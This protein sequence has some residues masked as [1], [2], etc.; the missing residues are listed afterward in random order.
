MV[1]GAAPLGSLLA[2]WLVGIVG[3]RVVVTGWGVLVLLGGLVF[4][5]QL[6]RLR[7]ARPVYTRLGIVPEKGRT[8]RADEDSVEG[9]R[10]VAVISHALWAGK[11][12]SSPRIIDSR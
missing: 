8:F 9:L 1:R 10:P 6:P 11:F 5:T 12:E 2:G 4:A 7:H 3:V